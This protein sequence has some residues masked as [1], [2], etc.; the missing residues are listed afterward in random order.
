MDTSFWRLEFT[1]TGPSWNSSAVLVASSSKTFLQKDLASEYSFSKIKTLPRNDQPPEV[2][3]ASL[4]A[5]HFFATKFQVSVESLPP[6]AMPAIQPERAPDK[7]YPSG[8]QVWLIAQAD[9]T[10][11][12]TA[13]RHS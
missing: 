8:V 1:G 3:S 12:A 4:C 5:Q 11:N 7:V 13:G 9:A 6:P 10:S 2:L